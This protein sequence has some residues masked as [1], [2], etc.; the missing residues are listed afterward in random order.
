MVRRADEQG[1]RRKPSQSPAEYARRLDQALPS[2]R[3]DIDSITEAFM[4]A[5]YS[6]REVDADKANQVKATWGRIRRALQEKSRGER[7]GK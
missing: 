7:A 3:E 2:A 6:R 4:E 1:W 5:R